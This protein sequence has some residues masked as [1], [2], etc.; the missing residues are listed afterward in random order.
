MVGRMNNALEDR[1]DIS[2]RY[3]NATRS[4]NL[5]PSLDGRTD[6]D[7]LLA[8]GIASQ[9]SPEL[10]LAMEVY[11]MAVNSDMN[12][13][14]NVVEAADSWLVQRMTRGGSRPIS[15]PA[16]RQLII[17]TLN[18]WCM[19]ICGYCAGTGKIAEMV[20]GTDTLA[21]K[22]SDQLCGSCRGTGKRPLARE[23]PPA[24][25]R[26]AEWMAAE[27]DRLV[28]VNRAAMIRLLK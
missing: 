11:R 8:A 10:R 18:W 1:P 19:P 5:T 23:V 15:R 6:A 22:L 9:K 17:D 7:V 25:Q 20:E 24:L 13:L 28:E 14:G 26:H 16:R 21:G 2:E 27:L 12:G 4:G 3:A